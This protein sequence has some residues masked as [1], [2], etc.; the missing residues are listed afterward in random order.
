MA[1]KAPTMDELRARSRKLYLGQS[2][3]VVCYWTANGADYDEAAAV[4]RR[5]Y[6]REHPGIE[7]FWAS[8]P[9]PSERVAELHTEHDCQPAPCACICGCDVKLGC[10]SFGGL[11]GV[12]TVQDGRGNEAH[13]VREEVD[14]G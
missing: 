4:L 3:C 6:R 5:H 8:L 11:C 9:T 13:G 10:T 1:E 7:D 12:C 2:A 14:R